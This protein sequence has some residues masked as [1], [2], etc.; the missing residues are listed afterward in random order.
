MRLP[1]F[2][3]F[4]KRRVLAG[5]AP[6]QNLGAGRVVER[7]NI[8]PLKAAIDPTEV[9]SS[10]DQ[11]AHTARRRFVGVDIGGVFHVVE[12]QQ[13]RQAEP[14]ETSLG[15]LDFYDRVV[16]C[17]APAE[18]GAERCVGGIH[19]DEASTLNGLVR[20]VCFRRVVVAALHI[21]P[22]HHG[23]RVLVTVHVRFRE[24]GLSDTARF[25][26]D[27]TCRRT[28]DGCPLR[29]GAGQ[30]PVKGRQLGRTPLEIRWLFRK[31]KQ[32]GVVERQLDARLGVRSGQQ[33][34]EFERVTRVGDR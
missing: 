7:F 22:G 30:R 29:V 13:R 25:R 23:E 31:V 9:V 10:G 21:K 18:F 8:N 15:L 12:H 16:V 3:I 27:R 19:G 1:A 2:I 11:R 17:P 26:Q 33:V 24:R 28:D 32:V 34:V 14:F 4:H 6:E 20:A 5:D